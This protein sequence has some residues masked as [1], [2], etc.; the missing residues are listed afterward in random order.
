MQTLCDAH[1]AFLKTDKSQP[2]YKGNVTSKKGGKPPYSESYR[3]DDPFD[4]CQR[5]TVTDY[6]MK[7]DLYIGTCSQKLFMT[8]IAKHVE[9]L[10]VA[11]CAFDIAICFTDND[12]VSLY[13]RL[14]VF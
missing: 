10:L 13:P 3:C 2:S 4:N 6:T 8:W 1:G 9:T 11:F 14:E 5:D 7:C 12:K